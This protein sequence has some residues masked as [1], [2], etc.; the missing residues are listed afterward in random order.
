MPGL[1]ALE[2]EGWDRATKIE[3]AALAEQYW[4]EKQARLPTVGSN[5][6]LSHA[7]CVFNDNCQIVASDSLGEGAGRISSPALLTNVETSDT[8]DSISL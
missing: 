3:R 5:G 1:S 8:E 6:V 4:R 2:V 7:N